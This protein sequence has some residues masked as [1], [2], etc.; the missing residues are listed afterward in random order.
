[1]ITDKIVFHITR[2]MN[3]RHGVAS[4]L[5]LLS[6]LLVESL[7]ERMSDR[8][9]VISGV[10][11]PRDVLRGVRGGPGRAGDGAGAPG[12]NAA[13]LDGDGYDALLLLSAAVWQVEPQVLLSLCRGRLAVSLEINDKLEL[14]AFM[15]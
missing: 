8:L 3:L 14:A 6:I 7:T 15:P 5:Q 4:V 11:P 9:V 2:N 12:I 1:M 10:H 13:G